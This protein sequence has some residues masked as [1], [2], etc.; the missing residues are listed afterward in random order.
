M[1]NVFPIEIWIY[2]I[3]IIISLPEGSLCGS[4]VFFPHQLCLCGTT[5]LSMLN[6]RLM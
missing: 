3:A 2:S 1:E 6:C 4:R 5:P